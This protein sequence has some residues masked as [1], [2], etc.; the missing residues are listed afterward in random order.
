M[1]VT[2]AVA[3][4]VK[5]PVGEMVPELVDHVTA[6]LLLP[7]SVA[8]NWSEWPGATV[9][10]AGEIAMLIFPD[11]ACCAPVFEE[12]G[13]LDEA[14]EKVEHAVDAPMAASNG[15]A[16]KRNWRGCEENLLWIDFRGLTNRGNIYTFTPPGDCLSANYK[17]I[18]P[19]N[20]CRWD[21][22]PNMR[23][24]CTFSRWVNQ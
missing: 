15:R 14:L 20:R 8:V 6:E 4:A 10:M 12:E 21:V 13:S 7:L 5:S 2:A 16:S 3:G 1:V 24:T 11:E 9:A 17:G 22:E 23:R 19:V 18:D